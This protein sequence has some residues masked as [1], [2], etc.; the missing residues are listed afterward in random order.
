V[1]THH[2][3]LEKRDTGAPLRRKTDDR[4]RDGYRQP[5]RGWGE[6]SAVTGRIAAFAPPIRR[7]GVTPGAFFGGFRTPV[8]LYRVERSR[9]AGIRN[10]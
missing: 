1:R 3:T 7:Q 5:A 9:R 10:P 4:Q 2:A 8:P 6:S